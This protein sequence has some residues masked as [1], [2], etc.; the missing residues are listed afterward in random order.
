MTV[1]V[2]QL[3]LYVRLLA[4]LAFLLLA[5][6]TLAQSPHFI[7]FTTQDGLPSN[8]TY[9][10]LQD[11]AGFIWIGTDHGVAR[12]DGTNF[13]TFTTRDGLV[14]NLVTGLYNGRDGKIWCTSYR[15]GLSII[16][17]EEATVPDWMDEL[18]PA[19][20]LVNDLA[21]LKDGSLLF[22]FIESDAQL[23][24]L[25]LNDSGDV[26]IEREDLGS[27]NL[28]F[29]SAEHRL[30]ASN[31]VPEDSVLTL[32]YGDDRKRLKISLQEQIHDGL[33]T[34]SDHFFFVAREH[35]Y[36]LTDT[37]V[38]HHLL[39][40]KALNSLYLDT[41]GGL[42]IGMR[43]HGAYLFRP[44]DYRQPARQLL[45][46][47]SVTSVLQDHEGGFWFSTLEDGVFYM[48]F[49]EVTT[50]TV[51]DG[52]PHQRIT[53]S[54]MSDS[55][56]WLA[57]RDGSL[58][59][60][61][62]SDLSSVSKIADYRYI[63][64]MMTDKSGTVQISAIPFLGGSTGFHEQ[65][66][67][68]AMIEIAPNEFLL[69]MTSQ[70]ICRTESDS[71]RWET[72][73]LPRTHCMAKH[74]DGSIWLGSI[75]GLYRYKGDQVTQHFGDDAF[76]QK[77]IRCIAF[78]NERAFL[79]INGHGILVVDQQ[80]TIL[81]NTDNVLQSNF[82]H[83]I[84]VRNGIVWVA[85]SNGIDHFAADFRLDTLPVSMHIG[86]GMGLPDLSVN[87]LHF[88]G[89]SLWAITDKGIA[90]LPA[91]LASRDSESDP[92]LYITGVS[93]NGMPLDSHQMTALKY[94]QNNV[95]IG[96]QAIS[97]RQPASIR[98]KYRLL[99]SSDT[100][101]QITKDRSISYGDLA[102]GDY[103]FEVHAVNTFRDKKE[104]LQ[105]RF[106]VVTPFWL[107]LYFYL[108]LSLM[109]L[110][111][112]ALFAFW[113]ISS[114]KKA[115]AVQQEI[116]S[117]SYNALRAQMRPHFIYNS[118][119]ALRG[120]I[121]HNDPKAS[122]SY[123]ESFSSLVQRIF[124]HSA[125]TSVPLVEEIE[126]LKL[127]VDLQQKRYPDKLE[128]EVSTTGDIS[129]LEVPPLL[130]QPFIENSIEH[131]IL[132]SQRPGRLT[133][134]LQRQPHV[135]KVVITDNG[136]GLAKSRMINQRKARFLG[137]T[138]NKKNGAL[139]VSWERIMSVAR[140]ADID[141]A[142]SIEDYKNTESKEGTRVSFNLPITERHDDSHF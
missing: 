70:G 49:S 23:I 1:N 109:V 119:N 44:E 99:G 68:P 125:E 31:Y 74:P 118:L 91:D 46:G 111:L 48:P 32:V 63:S 97:Y 18:G 80:D 72:V 58:L 45:K 122:I 57:L 94:D 93:V 133:L 19:G 95:R 27:S 55:L 83:E 141:C 4:N 22:S 8:E 78:H 14:S 129:K 127:Y 77:D 76:L 24:R 123:L 107:S 92:R 75:N 54:A 12:F 114:V 79:G 140:A 126:T 82:S 65:M 130:L 7:H 112:I 135:L 15:N 11:S 139:N 131:G 52:I 105:V 6:E 84:K 81:L 25:S 71:T 88:R 120:F 36:A 121:L 35:F 53:H 40:D 96:F 28:V 64:S 42:W 10:L 26:R 16:A 2:T 137:K 66:M 69:A 110:T 89:D 21:E 41:A 51:A 43:D 86:M 56:L 87:G 37:G 73:S 59:T 117:L 106:S 47:Y 132:P 50:I 67:G 116:D 85:T 90:V 115:A 17:D 20:L 142:Y 138:R 101:W 33:G 29:Y 30:M 103:T 124:D 136:I 3:P 13:R 38:S 34:S 9:D 62:F 113:K 108:L 104:N 5:G 39:P 102:P 128:F 98:Y 100:V 60:L 134:D 61:P